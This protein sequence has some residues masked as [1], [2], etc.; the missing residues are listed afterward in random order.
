MGYTPHVLVIGGD[1]L[2]TAIARDLAIRGLDVTL[3]TRDTLG[4]E[5]PAEFGVLYSGARNV[6]R[7]PLARLLY[8]E[9]QT[10]Q[11]IADGC[12]DETGGLIV[13][14]DRER[15]EELHEAAESASIPA[16]AID[17]ETLREQEPGL[18][19]DIE[20]G[21][22]VPDSVVDP[23][24]LT[25]ANAK[26]AKEYGATI[27]SRTAVTEVAVDEGTV[28]TVRLAH[29][30]SPDAEF[31][32]AQAVTDGGKP[33]VPGGTDQTMPGEAVETSKQIEERETEEIDPDY[34]VNAAGGR[35][36]EVASRA[37]LDMQ[38]PTVVESAV[39]LDASPVD[40]VLTR[41]GPDGDET[42]V[43]PHQD[44][45][46]VGTAVSENGEMS[47]SVSA[48]KALQAQT[49]GMMPAVGDAAMLRADS[50]RR[51]RSASTNTGHEHKLLDHGDRDDCWGMTTVAGGSLTTHRY[52]AEQVA[53]DICTK[54]GIR[55]ECQ[56]DEI[57]LPAVDPLGV[58]TDRRAEGPVVCDQQSV[59]QADIEAA[60]EACDYP[61]LTE[62]LLR[63]R[64]PAH[65]PVE[66]RCAYRLAGVL[67]PEYEESVVSGAL[68]D[69]LDRHWATQRPVLVGDR[70]ET[71]AQT[72]RS[73]VETMNLGGSVPVI[74]P[75]D[76]DDE[77]S[78][79]ETTDRPDGGIDLA[80]F[81]D[82]R[83]TAR[84]EPPQVCERTTGGEL[85]R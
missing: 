4:A 83:D 33:G 3:A 7:E 58:A 31:E 81:A 71:A 69:F 1:V 39:L 84:R 49:E 52:V 18:S 2:A 66:G 13:S 74:D 62:A 38:I 79:R 60:F 22:S 45:V 51:L 82:G 54:F 72:Y 23:F 30:P 59:T 64:T 65:S 73:H 37:G 5:S 15:L 20:L 32:T 16:Q 41:Y 61:D 14:Q 78:D 67:Y 19:E 55:R 28:G 85:S 35:A 70:L 25:L 80:S 47:A 12:V 50:A 9:S 17:G 10:L 29:D 68:R 57:P 46:R 56:T 76:M 75:D 34:V 6:T 27:R 26:G 43:R 77:T 11:Q 8:R 63:M 42:T 44:V 36:R 40:T 53:D 24:R 21:I 48:V